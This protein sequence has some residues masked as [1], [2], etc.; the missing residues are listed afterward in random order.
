MITAIVLGGGVLKNISRPK[1]LIEFQGAPLI[2]RL[3]ES[4]E[5]SRYVD[6]VVFLIPQDARS[7]I[8]GKFRKPAYYL[9]SGANLIEKIYEALEFVKTEYVLIVP[10]DVPLLNEKIIDGFIEECLAKNGDGFYPIIEKQVLEKKFP[11][12]QRTYGRLKEGIFTGGN[13][14]LIKKSLFYLNRK[15][16]EEI[17]ESRK[18]AFKMA[19][20]A[21]ITVFL[22]GLLGILK[23]Q[24][25]EKRVSKLFNNADLKAVI[26]K[27]PEIGIDVD[28]PE[29]LDFLKKFEGT[30]ANG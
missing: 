18:D 3:A 16:I 2:V 15:F 24:D 6:E 20:V 27:Y 26:T 1:S 7:L 4:L 25:A 22:K 30:G 17:Y 14:F 23:I 28:K 21:G 8:E 29:D 12:T 5:K 11:G 19:K 10:V 9:T 13:L